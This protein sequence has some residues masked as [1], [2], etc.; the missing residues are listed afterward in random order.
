MQQCTSAPLHQC[1]N[2]PMQQCSS[3]PLHHRHHSPLNMNVFTWILARQ[4]VDG[5]NCTVAPAINELRTP[6]KS[7]LYALCH[8]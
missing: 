5:N 2:A 8:I 1:T 7:W 6:P 3:A 4:Q